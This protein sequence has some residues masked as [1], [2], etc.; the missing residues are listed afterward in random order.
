M[1]N[2]DERENR[3]IA[4]CEEMMAENFPNLREDIKSQ[5]LEALLILSRQIQRKSPVMVNL[6]ST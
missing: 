6:M 3:G 1:N 5:I 2:E 4:I